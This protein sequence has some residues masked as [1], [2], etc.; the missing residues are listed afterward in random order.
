MPIETLLLAFWLKVTVFSA[1]PEAEIYPL[2]VLSSVM[3]IVWLAVFVNEILPA[4]LPVESETSE[5][6]MYECAEVLPI[7]N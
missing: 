6:L 2:E 4:V 1:E 7:T 3:Y 5:P